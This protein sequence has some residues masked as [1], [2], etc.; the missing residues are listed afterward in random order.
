MNIIVAENPRVSSF[1]EKGM[2]ESVDPNVIYNYLADESR[3]VIGRAQKVIF[4]KCEAQISEVLRRANEENILITVSGG[5]TGITGSRVPLDGIV[6]STEEL[7]EVETKNENEELIEYFESGIKYSIAVGKDENGFYARAPPGIPLMIF[8]RMVENRDLFYPP[9]PTELSAFLGGTV[10]TNASGS[11]TFYYGST[12]NF[13]RRLRIVLTNGEVLDIRRGRIFADNYKFII[14]TGGENIE[15]EIPHY[16]MPNVEKNAAGLY[17]KP[18]MDLIDLFIGSEGILGVISEVEV[19]LIQKP[20]FVYTFFIH[21][22]DESEAIRLSRTLKNVA[23]KKELKILA[24]EFFD[25][26]SVEFIREK[27]SS[28]IPS[29][30]NAI[31]DILIDATEDTDNTLNKLAEILNKH[32]VLEALMMDTRDAKEIR[33]ALP[34]SI[35]EFVRLRSV[36]KVATDIAVPDEYFNEMIHWYYKIGKESKIKYVIFGHIG[37]NHLHFNFL[38]SNEDELKT[39]MKLVTTLL[40][41]AVELKGTISA[42]HGVGKKYYLKNNQKRPFLELM[43]GHEGLIQIAKLKHALDPKHI[44]NIGNIVPMEY[45]T[46]I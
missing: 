34:E 3:I 10:A 39:A 27:Y 15:I 9:D 17:A 28:N 20:K 21:F 30:S 44:L 5:G 2:R 37:N 45:L 8:K 40:R 23:R 42:E 35:N 19:R 26:N 22:S 4:P 1:C 24:I 7:T 31:I 25:K 43:Y 33:H 36:H 11:M 46:K 18:G 38:P 13:V 29:N 41:K 12:R 32:N 16:I 6:L 14:I